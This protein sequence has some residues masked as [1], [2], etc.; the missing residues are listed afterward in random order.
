ME[1]LEKEDTKERCYFELV[2]LGVHVICPSVLARWRVRLSLERY[3]G[4]MPTA[5]ARHFRGRGWC[6]R[7]TQEVSGC[8]QVPLSGVRWHQ[9]RLNALNL[10]QKTSREEWLFHR[11][12]ILSF[13]CTLA[14]QDVEYSGVVLLISVMRY[15]FVAFAN[16]WF[17]VLFSYFVF[18]RKRK[19]R[20]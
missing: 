18:V 15:L 4:P 7:D 8:G 6:Q 10:T 14:A 12:K 19:K 16:V 20:K 11:A 1:T 3:A 5:P 2:K 9:L 17:I 13:I